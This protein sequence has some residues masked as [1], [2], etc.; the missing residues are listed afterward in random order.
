M[1]IILRMLD[2]LQ[3]IASLT[4]SPSRLRVLREQAECIVELAEGSIESPSDRVRLESRLARVREALETKSFD[5][6][7]T[8]PSKH[9]E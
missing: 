9:E 3:T 1:A 8:N 6:Q 7:P 2:A 4:G 5:H